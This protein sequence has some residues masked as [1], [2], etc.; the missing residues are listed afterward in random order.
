[1]VCELDAEF[2]FCSLS[3]TLRTTAS[4]TTELWEGVRKGA[5]ALALGLRLDPGRILKAYSFS[6]MLANTATS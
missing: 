3:S 5:R 6:L 1:M 2:C 4:L